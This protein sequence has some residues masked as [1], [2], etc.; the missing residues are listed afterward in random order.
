LSSHSA[1]FS[2]TISGSGACFTD[3]I[4]FLTNQP[5]PPARLSDL[6]PAGRNPGINLLPVSA[7]WSSGADEV[8][9]CLSAH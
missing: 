5:P 3:F 6:R 2:L 8:Y 9:G 7:Y 4:N 1:I